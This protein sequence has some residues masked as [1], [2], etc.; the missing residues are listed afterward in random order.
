MCSK[1]PSNWE[2]LQL[3]F[4]SVCCTRIVHNIYGTS[5]VER[6]LNP[7]VHLLQLGFLWLIIIYKA[8]SINFEE[9]QF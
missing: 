2:K 6:D 4:L 8:R 9:E 3:T 1:V 7:E 5:M